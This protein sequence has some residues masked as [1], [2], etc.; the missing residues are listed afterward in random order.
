MPANENFHSGTIETKKDIKTRL[1][2]SD[3]WHKELRLA[4]A[5]EEDWR[6]SG[7][8]IIR[9]YRAEERDYSKN[10]DNQDVRKHNILWANVETMKPAMYDTTP[11][12]DV[13]RRFRDKDEAAKEASELIERALS[14]SVDEYDFD[15]MMEA[16]VTDYLL[17][18]RGLPKVVYER[19]EPDE[20]ETER[21][22]AQIDPQ[23]GQLPLEAEFDDQGQACVEQ[24]GEEGFTHETV[25]A[26]IVPWANFRRGPGNTWSQVPWIAYMH[27]KTRDELK[28]QFGKK[29]AETVDLDFT[30]GQNKA[31]KQGISDA[32]GDSDVFKRATIYEIW[33]KETREVIWLA[34]SSN[35]SDGDIL[36]VD[37]DPL[38]LQGFFN[39]PKPLY[40]LET[41]DS[42]VP[43]PDYLQ[44]EDQ[45]NELDRVTNRINNLYQVLRMRGAYD[46][47]I[48][49]LSDIL[50]QSDNV[51]IPITVPGQVYERGGLDKSI[52]TVPIDQVMQVISGL[53]QQR[54]LILDTIFEITGISDIVRG[55]SNA[56]ETATAQNIKTQFGNL[57]MNKR[58]RQVQR[59]ARDVMRIKAEII[60]EKFAPENIALM[61]NIDPQDIS[62]EAGELLR[63]DVIRDFRIDIETDSTITKQ[64]TKDKQAVREGFAAIGN[65]IQTVAPMVQTGFLPKQAVLAMLQTV[66][67]RFEFGREVE[68]I[69]DQSI[70]QAVQAEE[71]EK[72]EGEQPSP[73]EIE[74]QAEAQKIQLELQ[75]KQIELQIKQTELETKQA[76]AEIK[77]VEM[78]SKIA[79]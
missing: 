34:K 47:A 2:R 17:V 37:P 54:Q 72:Q 20:A 21:V 60:A 63:R 61:A 48:T 55:V 32:T 10:L 65:F 9:R 68:D 64:L 57:R 46:S 33:D 15:E 76:E 35:G 40:S 7:H 31:D 51:F 66:L 41:T 50:D 29:K 59:L 71:K 16:V 25:R 26:E 45:A 49:G 69:V 74:A 38:G 4:D 42:L 73:E 79:G 13:R 6:E 19:V 27:L 8:R 28:K 30:D 24:Q 43:S 53:F 78:L 62:E 22:P 77:P 12:P 56:G 5:Q 39:C 11:I 14:F 36:G 70:Q 52:W 3:R 23:T 1:D 75:I 67:R 18:G 58:Q 44:Y